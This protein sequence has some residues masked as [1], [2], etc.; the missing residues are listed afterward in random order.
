M[1]QMT[2]CVMASPL[3]SPRWTWPS[4]TV[5]DSCKS[6]VELDAHPIYNRYAAQKTPRRKMA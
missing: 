4:A 2:T 3:Y 6:A 5:Y 1:M